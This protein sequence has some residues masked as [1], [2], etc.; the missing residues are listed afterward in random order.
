MFTRNAT[1]KKV[2]ESQIHRIYSIHKFKVD[3]VY[4]EYLHECELCK[5]LF[6]GRKTQV[7]IIFPLDLTFNP[8]S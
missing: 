8:I 7:N 3:D 4:E 1:Q 5:Y 2:I 6:K